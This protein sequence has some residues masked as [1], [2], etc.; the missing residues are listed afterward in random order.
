MLNHSNYIDVDTGE[1]KVASEPTILRVLAIGSCVVVAAFNRNKRIG[2]LAH[3]MLPGRSSKRSEQDKKTRYTEDAIDDL[4]K[5]LGDLG[6]RIDELEISLIGGANILGG[7]TIS[8][9]TINSVLDYLKEL[10]FEPK[11]QRLGGIQRRTMSFDLE[12]GKIFYTE[13]DHVVKEM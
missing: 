7:V 3:I 10:G 12:T 5:Q 2:G 13:G 9:E 8:N 6:T 11:Q 1:V 4:L